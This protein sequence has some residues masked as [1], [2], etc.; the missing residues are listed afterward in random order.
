VVFEDA[1]VL[2]TTPLS[3]K[4][5]VNIMVKFPK[6]NKYVCPKVDTLSMLL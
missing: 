5:L 2:G 6:R 3:A 4:G 1:G